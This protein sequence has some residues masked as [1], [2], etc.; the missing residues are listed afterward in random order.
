MANLDVNCLRRDY[1]MKVVHIFWSFVYGGIETMLVNIANEQV[2]LGA[3]VSI[4][5]I[6]DM[7][8]GELVKRFSPNVRF[9]CLRRRLHTKGLGFMRMLN[10][11]LNEIKPSI[12]HLH[13][14]VLINYLDRPWNSTACSV[15]TLHDMPS[16]S[17]GM[18]CRYGNMIG[19]LFF[20]HG[21]NTRGIDRIGH[22]FSISNAVAKALKDGYGISSDVVLNGIQT[23]VFVHRAMKPASSPFK[24]VQVGRLEHDKK[25]NDL[26]L[27][28]VRYLVQEQNKPILLTFIGEGKSMDF[29][30]KQ[31]D[32]Y[33]ME[34]VV[35]FLGSK[36]QEYISQHLCDYDLFVQPSR[37]EGFGLT[38]A[39]AIAAQLPVLVS[40]G[41]GPSEVTENDRFGWTFDNGNVSDLT[42]KIDYLIENYTKALEKVPSAFFHVTQLYDVSVTARTYLEYY[43]KI[44]K[45]Q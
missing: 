12:V 14:S 9:I 43:E 21:G 39:E 23:N 33:H 1:N 36:S 35:T 18:P 19:N 2:K 13:S 45:G 30:K 11:K 44:L 4:I 16:G 7:I 29:L 5:I 40:K 26:L 27:D 37:Y 17:I 6:N 32:S 41:Q 10:A 42:S 15:L 22:V 28:A 25:G 31:V 8:S 20:H 24:I 3:E 38:V 34:D